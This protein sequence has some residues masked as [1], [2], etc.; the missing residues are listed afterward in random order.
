LEDAGWVSQG[1]DLHQKGGTAAED[2]QHGRE[3]GLE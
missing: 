1:E 2:R 3:Q